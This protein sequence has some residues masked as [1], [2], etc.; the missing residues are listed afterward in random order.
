MPDLDKRKALSEYRF[1]DAVAT[2]QTAKLCID[3]NHYKDAIN[4]CYY[5]AFYA[6]KSVLAIKGIDF[7]RHKDVV[8]YF[9]HHYVKGGKFSR[10]LGKKIAKLK[11][12]RENSDYDDFYLASYEEAI[13]QYEALKMVIN[14]DQLFLENEKVTNNN[15]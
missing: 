6:I 3:N 7:K 9:N 14:E 15:E 5:G 4:Q 11:K 8:A 2:M 10:E 1:N 12:K 13:E